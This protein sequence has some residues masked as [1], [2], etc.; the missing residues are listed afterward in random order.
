MEVK[1]TQ[2]PLYI[3]EPIAC[4]SLFCRVFVT[5][6]L[7]KIFVVMDVILN[8]KS[9]CLESSGADAGR[10]GD[11]LGLDVWLRCDPGKWT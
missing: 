5:I 11:Y 10:A 3:T 4:H 6:L 7:R 2:P 1:L 9:A 8:A